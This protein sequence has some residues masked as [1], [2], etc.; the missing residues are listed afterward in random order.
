VTLQPYTLQATLGEGCC[1]KASSCSVPS[2]FDDGPA[3][4]S[5]Q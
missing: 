2:G 1:A 4:E 5:G 3:A